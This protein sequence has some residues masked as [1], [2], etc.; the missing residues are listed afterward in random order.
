M[1]HS[2]ALD[3]KNVAVRVARGELVMLVEKETHDGAV[4]PLERG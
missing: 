3:E 4:E 2:N 1:R